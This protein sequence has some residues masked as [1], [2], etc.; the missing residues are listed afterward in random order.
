M[1]W[2]NTTNINEKKKETLSFTLLTFLQH[3]D[4]ASFDDYVDKELARFEKYL[5]EEDGFKKLRT[6]N[7]KY[8]NSLIRGRWKFFLKGIYCFHLQ[9]W[10]GYFPKND[11]LVLDGDMLT[12]KPW[13]VMTEV[14][15]FL[16][17]PFQL[18]EESFDLNPNT[19]FYCLLKEG[20]RQCLGSNKGNT[21]TRSSD[22]HIASK[23]SKT[24]Q[25][26]LNGFFKTYE[27]ELLNI[28]KKDFLWLYS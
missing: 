20:K 18:T 14:Q 24:S 5:E 6:G 15:A 19:G 8:Y 2:R 25:D 9:R 11:V 4:Y 22:G 21:R 16:K 3:R 23:M 26:T 27:S 28:M 7:D 1:L 17:I 13:K 12:S 10:Y